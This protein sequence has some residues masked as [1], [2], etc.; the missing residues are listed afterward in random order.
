M[1][2]LRYNVAMSLD[3]YIADARGGFDWIP[4]DDSVDFAGLFARVDT[5][6]M[7]RR[8]YET[9]LANGELPWHRGTRVYVV[10]STL[11][12]GERDGVNFVRD[13][14]VALARALRN[15]PGDGEIWL[16]G[17]GQLFATLLAANQVDAI[18][19]T[20]V[21]VLLGG[22]VPV[23]ASLRERASL[24]LNHSHVYPSG[25]VALHYAVPGATRA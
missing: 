22:G 11:P 18:E 7:G 23:V 20:V 21:P 2:R 9:V 17:G 8:T 1:R 14:P 6:L 24:T 15:E 3:G 19:V 10:S 13:D 5:F 16:F 4:N 25:M 12:E